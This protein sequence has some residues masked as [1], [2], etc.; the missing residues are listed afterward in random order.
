MAASGYGYGSPRWENDSARGASFSPAGAVILSLVLHGLLLGLGHVWRLPETSSRVLFAFLRPAP[1]VNRPVSPSVATESGKTEPGKRPDILAR[2]VAS[3]AASVGKV[4]GSKVT[5]RA[6]PSAVSPLAPTTE[7]LSETALDGDGVRRYRLALGS[8]MRKHRH[9]TAEARKNR[10]QGRVDLQLTIHGDGRAP[11][12]S[13]THSSGHPS[14][15]GQARDM[16]LSAA[17]ETDVPESLRGRDFTLP[18]SL[19]YELAD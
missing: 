4:T 17:R 18:L 5:G 10:W 9:D 1:G 11:V 12:V 19:W 8:G 6:L 7:P 13:V 15:D 14:L 3:G 16:L 2:S